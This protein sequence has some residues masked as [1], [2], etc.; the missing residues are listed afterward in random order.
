[1]AERARVRA[2]RRLHRTGLDRTPG[3][4][5]R[6]AV[7]AATAGEW[8]GVDLASGGFLRSRPLG[9]G[10]RA[11]WE[12]RGDPLDVALVEIGEDLE[13]PDPARPEA[14]ALAGAPE[15]IG[16][17]ARRSRQRLLRQ[18]ATPEQPGAGVIGSRGPS[19]AYVDCD[20]ASP[21]VALLAVSRRELSC[22]LDASGRPRCEFS[23]AGY[24]N[25][26]PLLDPRALGALSE[27][28]QAALDAAAL[29]R[30]VGGKPGYVLVGLTAVRDGH[31]PKA[32]LS[33]LP[34]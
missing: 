4:R 20:L 19:I 11:G 13:P 23:W 18:L 6:C 22:R 33:I 2:P 21:S 1:M 28:G 31:A 8:A 9:E 5:L 10:L 30:A 7:L 26:L 16:R 14:V 34:R 29:S 15:R 3:R 24:R 12:G 32:V 25:S 17:L 27:A